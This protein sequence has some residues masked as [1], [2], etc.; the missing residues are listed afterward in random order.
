MQIQKS[1]KATDLFAEE[2]KR[3][4][5]VKAEKVPECCTTE[6][7]KLEKDRDEKKQEAEASGTTE[8]Q[9]PEAGERKGEPEQDTYEKLLDPVRKERETTAQITET[10]LNNE[11]GGYPHRNPEAWERTGD[12]RPINAL[13]EEMGDASDEGKR[14]RQAEAE[15]QNKATPRILDKN[16]GSQLSNPKT[17]LVNKAFNLKQV[18]TSNAQKY[19]K[20]L[21]YKSEVE[22]GIKTAS[23]AEIK[24]LDSE[25]SAIM[26]KAQ[27]ENRLLSQAEVTQVTALKQKKSSLLRMG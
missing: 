10:R 26:E 23:F 21:L 5:P 22:N 9:L 13:K 15:K 14:E 1:G 8:V 20:Y 27:A 16:P 17:K 12:K 18:K 3:L 24:Q 11:K 7:V 4:M 25:M 6:E 19:G 2:L